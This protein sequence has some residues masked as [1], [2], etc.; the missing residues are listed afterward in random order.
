[1]SEET[2][3]LELRNYPPYWPKLVSVQMDK[4][5]VIAPRVPRY[6]LFSGSLRLFSILEI[7]SKQYEITYVATTGSIDADSKY[8][9]T[10]EE[11]GLTV[12]VKNY[13]LKDISHRNKFRLALLEFYSTAE[14]YLPRIKLLQVGCPI[15]IDSVDV[16]YLRERLK[17]ETSGHKDD[18]NRSL[19]TRK[20]ELNIYRKAET[21]ITVTEE[22]A[23][24]LEKDLPAL[25]T[26]V[27]PNV[28]RLQI[29]G[30]EAKKNSLV[31]VGGFG[32]D[33]NIDAV[34]FFCRDVLPLIRREI[35]DVT[36]TVVG[37]HPPEEI[38]ALANDS[39]CVEGYVPSTTP[40]LHGSYVSVAPL[41]FGSGMKGKVGEAMA[42]GIPVVT[43]SVGAQGMNL[44]NRKTT[45][46]A[47]APADMSK[48][49]IELLQNDVLYKTLQSNAIEYV[50]QNLTPDA[51]KE[52]ILAAFERMANKRPKRMCLG[53]KI[54]FLCSYGVTCLRALEREI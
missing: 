19:E 1:M 26:E 54:S 42:H 33:P 7:L 13:S 12:F 20:R 24:I 21:V 16:H 41:R 34:L 22:D 2:R 37:S 52:R 46:I 49:I 47:D 18:L 50:R 45:I 44:V 32:H 38:R 43:T 8:I 30:D 29:S 6:D 3:T 53:E 9:S 36:F 27:I 39:V 17:Y 10:L 48:G 25:E 11:M 14:Y 23:N 15:A 28:H 51:L 35:P 31:F 40:Y 5:L 4:L